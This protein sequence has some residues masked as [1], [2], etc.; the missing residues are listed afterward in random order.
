MDEFDEAYEKRKPA[1]KRAAE[2]LHFILRGVVDHIEDRRLVRAGPIQIRIK[3][4]QSL[5]RKAKIK[6]WSVEQAL[7]QT[8]D[9]VGGRVIVNNLVDIHRV[10]AL[11]RES[12]FTEA[13]MI[14]R[15]DYVTDPQ[16]HGYRAL[17]L[18]FR[19]NVPERIGYDFVRCEVQVRTRLQDSW[20]ELSHADIY[21]RDDLSD[22]LRERFADLASTLEAADRIAGK[23]RERVAQ[24]MTP[25]EVRPHLDR[26]SA[27]G[28]AYV[29]SD[30]FGRAPPDYVVTEAVHLCERLDIEALNTLPAILI[31]QELRD[32][33]DEIYGEKLPIPIN[34][35]TFLLAALHAL[36]GGDERAVTFVQARARDDFEEI[37]ATARIELEQELPKT[38]QGMIEDLEKYGNEDCISLYAHAL[39]INEGCA[40]CPAEIIDPYSFA[41]AAINYY[42]LEDPQ[43]IEVA[44]R[45]QGA[46]LRSGVDAG[47]HS[48]SQLCSNC[49][50]YLEKND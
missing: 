18:N 42:E 5:K 7:S 49:A 50:S 46:I 12:V 37:D 19:I 32:R 48:D 3:S 1:L 6:G 31:R 16:D 47:G 2:Q 23:I 8:P 17:H 44:D 15:Q 26:V 21:K 11:L 9:L 33:L 34:N 4:R 20:A 27:S 39:G 14:K 24:T 43:A 35:E 13:N 41:E 38:V 25:P 45:I 29:F 10:E 28:L 40:C 22:D 30:T 36:A